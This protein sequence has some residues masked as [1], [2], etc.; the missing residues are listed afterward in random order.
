MTSTSVSVACP[1]CG[2]RQNYFIDSPSTVERPDLV[3]CDTDEG[4]CD[5]Y[6]VVFSHIR[7]EKFVRAAKIEGEQ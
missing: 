2:C 6:F 4:G 3:N 5:K 1:L 7:V